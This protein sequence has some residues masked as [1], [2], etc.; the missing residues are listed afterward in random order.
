M[1]KINLKDN[2]QSFAEVEFGDIVVSPNL[3]YFTFVCDASYDFN[4]NDTIWFVDENGNKTPLTITVENFTAFG[5]ARYSTEYVVY[6]FNP[7][8]NEKY[9]EYYDG[10]RYYNRAIAERTDI[11]GDNSIVINGTPYEISDKRITVDDKYYITED[12]LVTSD[13]N[14]FYT[15]IYLT[16]DE[17]GNNKYNIDLQPIDEENTNIPIVYEV[18]P[19]PK[20]MS[21]VKVNSI[22][23]RQ[24]DVN[25][26]IPFS[27]TEKILYRDKYYD[28]HKEYVAD[29]NEYLRTVSG[30]DGDY[31]GTCVYTID[32]EEIYDTDRIFINDEQNT[33]ATIERSEMSDELGASCWL[34]ASN[35]VLNGGDVILAKSIDNADRY[36]LL[37]ND[38]VSGTESGA[39]N[40]YIY[41][42]NNEYYEQTLVQYKD[43]SYHPYDFFL[44]GEE[45]YE[46]HY[47]KEDNSI[48][49]I[50]YNN[51]KQYFAFQ[52]LSNP[53]DCTL[54]NKIPLLRNNVTINNLFKEYKRFENDEFSYY[55]GYFDM[56]YNNKGVRVF[57]T[58]VDNSGTQYRLA[59]RQLDDITVNLAI[60]N[61]TLKAN[62][63]NQ[64]IYGVRRYTFFDID[65][66]KFKVYPT[67]AKTLYQ[68]TTE[69]TGY[70]KYTVM[71]IPEEY[72]LLVTSIA[73]VDKFVCEPFIGKLSDINY[74]F[75]QYLLE[76]KELNFKASICYDISANFHNFE[77]F[78]ETN[79]FGD[80]DAYINDEQF[81]GFDTSVVSMGK[82]QIFKDM[83]YYELPLSFVQTVENNM[84]QQDILED[85]FFNVE[86]EKAINRIVDMEKDLY[87]PVYQDGEVDDCVNS[88]EFLNISKIVFNLHFR[89]RDLETW[90]IN[91]D[92]NQKPIHDGENPSNLMS[93]SGVS[94]CNWFC[95][96]YYNGLSDMTDSASETCKHSDLL[97]F[98]NFTNDD[99][100]YQ[101]S[102]V[103]KSFLR[104]LFYD[105]KNPT[106]QK[107]LYSATVWL[108]ENLLYKKYINNMEYNSYDS[109]KTTNY[110][111]NILN[112]KKKGE[113]VSVDCEP[114]NYVSTTQKSTP[115]FN[116]DAR[117]D[118]QFIIKNRYQTSNSSEGFY[119]HLFKELTAR[120]HERTIYM[121][122]QFNHAGEGKVL[123]FM[124]P[125]DNEKKLIT[126]FTKKEIEE[127]CSGSTIIELYDRM[128]ID[129][130]IKYDKDL[131]RYVWY[132]P[133]ELVDEKGYNG[134]TMTFNLFEIKLKDESFV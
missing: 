5:E 4:N 15:N 13:G 122:V 91:E 79:V 14:E 32:G 112:D 87:Y 1:L 134:G 11:F 88:K 116:E 107:L 118:S 105:T 103:G 30:I 96:D 10:K 68:G 52:D 64:P 82:I 42:K 58:L 39:T 6:D 76:Y 123:N 109:A 110:Y 63:I 48:G 45:E 104:L 117:L 66:K 70:F 114:C 55:E 128:Y 119:L 106:N 77:F 92:N 2:K 31:S 131:D 129:I 29:K 3:D 24:I 36:V 100:F 22:P 16:F 78:K 18:Y 25:T 80:E 83:S 38:G 53:N 111:Y 120:L 108:D 12:N 127:L 71:N 46:I 8:I 49:Y 94:G 56:V 21:K 44:I 132:L 115:N 81:F 75:E 74:M 28:V 121:K 17:N 126:Q 34:Y 61:G 85:R 27:Y 130:K 84:M 59:Y 47:T 113:G 43:G 72:R 35:E 62:A 86:N 54:F 90:K 33:I 65:G 57:A 99:I 101:K 9:V 95:I 41:H 26:I 97:T 93:Y 23:N 20:K 7:E 37:M 73:G 133:K 98:L 67:E 125:F 50:I 51:E 19:I 89:T 60:E 124:L 69:Q 40:F 102:K